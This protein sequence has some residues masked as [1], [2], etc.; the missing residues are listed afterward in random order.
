MFKINKQTDKIFKAFRVRIYPNKT[1]E[2]YFKRCFGIRR[3]V[4]NLAV[5]EKEKNFDKKWK[6]I[7]EILKERYKNEFPF[8]FKVNSRVERITLDNVKEAYDRYFKGISNK[9]KFKTKKDKYQ[10]FTVD[11]ATI[12]SK[13]RFVIAKANKPRKKGVKH[14]QKWKKPYQIKT[15]ED[16]SFLSDKKKHRLISVTIFTNGDNK[17]YASFKY[18]I[19]QKNNLNNENNKKDVVGIDLGLKTFAVQSDNLVAKFPK[20]RVLYYEEKIKVLQKILNRKQYGSN[21]YERVRLKL[22]KYYKKIANI[23]DDFL[24]KYTTWLC[25]NY[26]VIKIE[27]LNIE[28]MIKNRRFSKSILR[29][30]FGKFKALLIQKSNFYNTEVI[31]VDRFY[32][33]SKICSCCGYKKDKLK[34]SQRVYECDKCGFQLDR[35]L[36]AA[37]NISRF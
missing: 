27:D 31:L 7:K 16:I 3:L 30:K 23:V 15:A 10:S 33:S 13:N 12:K 6:E 14:K 32:P 25:K 36:N 24:Q 17:Y 29:Q 4:Y 11:R 22:N 9:P 8:V 34:L 2:Q 20:K 18:E 26:K 35:D 5:E 37:I 28:G 21:N 19:L 1:Q